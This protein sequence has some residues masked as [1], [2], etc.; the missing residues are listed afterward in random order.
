MKLTRSEKISLVMEAL[1]T[2]AIVILVYLA[3]YNIL[4]WLAR[5]LL[6]YHENSYL[7]QLLAGLRDTPYWGMTPVVIVFLTIAMVTFIYWRLKRRQRQYELAHIIDELHHIAD[8]DFSHRIEKAGYSSEMQH[9]IDSIHTLVESAVAAMEEERRIE[10]TKDELITN[11]SH[12]IRTPLTSIIG[13]IGLIESGA[14]NNE[15]EFDRYLSVASNKAKQMKRLVDDLFEYIKVRQPSTKL[16]ISHFDMVQLVE[17]LAIDFELDLDQQETDL[18]IEPSQDSIMMDGDAE[19][20]VRL[21]NNLVSNALKYGQAGQKIKITINQEYDQVRLQVANNGS[22]LPQERL[23]LIF[24]RFYRLEESRSSE[25]EGTGL[26]L[27]ISK[28]IAQLHHGSIEAKSQ[29]GWTIFEV[30]LPLT[31]QENQEGRDGHVRSQ[32]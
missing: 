13:Y 24:D 26:G 17:Q 25:I 8:G 30:V 32:A 29:D 12:D 28:S 2:A 6:R 5:Y 10:Q 19:Q 9:V 3:T 31:Y 21:M 1:V 20:L 16:N 4:T 14:Y 11:V 7:S 22:D 15:E 27:P 18:T 23:D